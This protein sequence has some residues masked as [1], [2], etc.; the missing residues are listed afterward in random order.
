MR[1]MVRSGGTARRVIVAVAVV[2]AS[3]AADTIGVSAAAGAATDT[4][5]LPPQKWT[6]LVATP[7]ASPR[8]VLGAD[9]RVHLVYELLVMN[10]SPSAMTLE[11]LETLDASKGDA[12]N[13]IVATS[14]GGVL[15]EIS[16]SFTNPLT[17]T[18][19]PFQTTRLFL[20]ATF[21]KN[22]TVPKVLEHRFQ[23]TLTPAAG[24]PP[25]TSATV[26]SGRTK[27][28]NARA[29]VIG[30]PL[31]GSRWVDA[32]GCCSPPSVHRTA[33]LPINGKIRASERFAIDF[34][35]LTP[36]NKLYTGP[37]DQLS[38][39]A[40]VGSKV[41]SVADGRVV[42]LQD[43][44]PD[45]TPPTFPQGY[46]LLQQL[47]NFVVVDIGHGRF[48]FYAHFQPNTLKVKVGDKVRRGQVLALMGNSGNSD[49]P[50]LH[51]GIQDG[52]GP[53]ASN[54]LP[55]VFSSFTTTGT[56]T[57][58]FDD[59]AAGATAEIG[60]AQAGRHKE[61]L[62]LENEVITFPKQ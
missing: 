33:T 17:L 46:T 36:D 20:D 58:P 19:G 44:R 53:F 1:R 50:H 4:T 60:P 57:N 37:R 42:G 41:L 26:V 43:G 13:K 38:S 62:P 7:I 29:V 54:S 24:V 28:S 51:F 34:A 47:G 27:V 2:V 23:F 56:I 21:D 40:Y 49:A 59:I 12:G 61:E 10:V 39:Y 3:L 45:E 52:P 8:P 55:Y 18:V 48:A 30:P 15:E 25:V 9:G 35:Q 11:R 5:G 16:R 31:E 6:S 14:E 32:I 22:A